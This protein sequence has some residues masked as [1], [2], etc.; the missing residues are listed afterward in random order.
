MAESLTLTPPLEARGSEVL[1]DLKMGGEIHAVS[2]GDLVGQSAYSWALQ[3]IGKARVARSCS[4]QISST[5]AASLKFQRL[6]SRRRLDIALF[7]SP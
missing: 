6:P 2:E 5:I 1:S 3:C 7:S 4:S